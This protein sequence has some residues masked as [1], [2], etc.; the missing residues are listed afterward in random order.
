MFSMSRLFL[1]V[2]P[3]AEGFHCPAALQCLNTLFAC[4]PGIR[5]PVGFKLEAANGRWHTSVAAWVAILAIP[6][7]RPLRGMLN[8][9]VK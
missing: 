6:C 1:V 3:A 8:E 7:R 5:V 2:A 4:S 9:D